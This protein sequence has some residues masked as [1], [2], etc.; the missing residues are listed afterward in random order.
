MPL[1]GPI[2]FERVLQL[3]YAPVRVAMHIDLKQ[4]VLLLTAEHAREGVL[5]EIHRGPDRVWQG[6]STAE[7][8]AKYNELAGFTKPADDFADLV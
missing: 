2:D 1:L 3:V 6:D 7:A 4:P 5:W 8:V